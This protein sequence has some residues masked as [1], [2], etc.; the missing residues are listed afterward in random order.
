MSDIVNLLK[1]FHKF[2]FYSDPLFDNIEIAMD[3]FLAQDDIRMVINDKY[4]IE[5]LIKLDSK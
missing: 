2:V 1:R 4:Q 5:V 3:S